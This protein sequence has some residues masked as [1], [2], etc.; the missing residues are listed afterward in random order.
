MGW[1]NLLFT[2]YIWRQGCCNFVQ[3]N[4]GFSL[5]NTKPDAEGRVLE[6]RIKHEDTELTLLNI[7]APNQDTPSF[8]REHFRN[9]TQLNPKEIIVAFDFNLVLDVQMDKEG[10]RK[11]THFNSQKVLKAYMEELNLID[12]WRLKH[13]DEKIFTWQSK[14][15]NENIKVRLDY[16]L[17]SDT[18]VQ[19][20]NKAEI[21]PKFSSDHSFPLLEINLIKLERGRGVWKFNTSLLR[22]KNFLEAVNTMLVQEMQ[23]EYESARHRW[24]IIKMRIRSIAIKISRKK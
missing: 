9:L 5:I 24:E 14:R 1:S 11:H 7:Y 3:K 23:T 12:I 17:I 13:L 21:K 16:F 19:S 15:G 22:E 8:F 2:W 6:V 4:F 10:G 18:L 20:V